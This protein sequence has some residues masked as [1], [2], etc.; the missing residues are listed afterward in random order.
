MYV[1]LSVEE[2]ETALGCF[3]PAPGKIAM[4]KIRELILVSLALW[5]TTICASNPRLSFATAFVA[6]L[7]FWIAVFLDTDKEYITTF[8]KKLA[9]K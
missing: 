8:R 2:T 7:C 4:K 6:A 9:K 3:A 5:L 1:D